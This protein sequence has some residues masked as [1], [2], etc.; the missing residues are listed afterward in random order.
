MKQCGKYFVIERRIVGHDNGSFIFV[1]LLN[2]SV[3]DSGR[4][5]FAKWF[6]HFVPIK[7]TWLAG[8]HFDEAVEKGVLVPHAQFKDQL[9][10]ETIGELS[11]NCLMDVEH[12]V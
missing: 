4:L 6:V 3:I 8:C 11:R 12:N 9:S 1:R 5:R 7:E 2:T 10:D